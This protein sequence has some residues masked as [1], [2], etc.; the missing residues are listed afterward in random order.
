ML[1][2]GVRSDHGP[3]RTRSSSFS[4]RTDVVR[5]V[6]PKSSAAG[7]YAAAKA[8]WKIWEGLM[9]RG[10]HAPWTGLAAVSSFAA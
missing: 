1:L 7:R 8:N 2:S 6:T 9:S 4:T 5:G 10:C 3:N